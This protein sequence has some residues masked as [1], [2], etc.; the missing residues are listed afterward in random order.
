MA[1]FCCYKGF[2]NRIGISIEYDRTTPKNDGYFS[3]KVSERMK[4]VFINI[5]RK[6]F[7]KFKKEIDEFSKTYNIEEKNKEIK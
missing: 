2:D 5:P 3:I 4:R 7:I 1:R 6:D